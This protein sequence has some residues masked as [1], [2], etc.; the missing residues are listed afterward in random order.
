MSFKWRYFHIFCICLIC[1]KGEYCNWPSQFVWCYV[2]YAYLMWMQSD[3]EKKL[4]PEYHRL[5]RWI[6]FGKL[7]SFIVLVN[8]WI[9]DIRWC[10]TFQHFRLFFC[11]NYLFFLTLK[12]DKPFCNRQLSNSFFIFIPFHEFIWELINFIRIAGEYLNFVLTVN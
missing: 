6:C 5:F 9:L 2:I 12:I 8:K 3:E 1:H 7:A 4:T 10:R 11:I